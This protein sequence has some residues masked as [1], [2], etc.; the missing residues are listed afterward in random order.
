MFQISGDVYVTCDAMINMVG[1]WIL[2][3]TRVLLYIDFDRTS[4]TSDF[5]FDI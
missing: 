2:V 3:S 1:Y 5:W 4:W